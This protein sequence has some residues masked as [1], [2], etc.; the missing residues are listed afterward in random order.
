MSGPVTGADGDDAVGEES[1]GGW[2]GMTSGITSPIHHRSTTDQGRRVAGDFFFGQTDR[3]MT[4][5]AEC[6]STSMVGQR[7]ES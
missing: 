5:E 4:Y 1:A 6:Y 7:R 2:I 3:A